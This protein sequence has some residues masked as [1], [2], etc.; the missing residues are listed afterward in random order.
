MENEVQNH[1][2]YQ[3]K[4]GS[5]QLHLQVDKEFSRLFLLMSNLGNYFKFLLTD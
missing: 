1:G 3:H 4:A 5:K 2:L